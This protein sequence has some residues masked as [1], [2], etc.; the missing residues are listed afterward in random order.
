MIEIIELHIDTERVAYS[1]YRAALHTKLREILEE[2]RAELPEEAEAIAK[3]AEYRQYDYICSLPS[4]EEEDGEYRI[5]G[6]KVKGID[7]ARMKNMERTPHD[8]AH[9]YLCGMGYGEFNT[10]EILDGFHSG[11]FHAD[12]E[13]GTVSGILHPDVA[14]DRKR[15]A[16]IQSDHKAAEDKAKSERERKE[17]EDMQ[18]ALAKRA[19]SDRKHDEERA[20]ELAD[21]ADFQEFA[22]EFEQ[23]IGTGPNLVSFRRIE[24]FRERTDCLNVFG[25]DGKNLEELKETPISEI[26]EIQYAAYD[27]LK[28]HRQIIC[29]R[30]EKTHQDWWYGID[31]GKEEAIRRWKE[32][33]VFAKISK[34]LADQRYREEQAAKD[35]AKKEALF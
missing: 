5:D 13:D 3:E 30:S 14:A 16:K 8:K 10:I 34:R 11:I 9:A 7:I 22:A 31:L 4:L 15:L 28:K 24:M 35:K 25:R 2:V 29:I 26:R 23:Q 32:D 21:D 6:K 27:L 1:D 20:A 17:V 12:Y 18:A 33:E 19:E